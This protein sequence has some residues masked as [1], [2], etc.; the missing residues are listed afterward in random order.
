M[1]ICSF[2]ED[3]FSDVKRFTIPKIVRWLA[4]NQASNVIFMKGKNTWNITTIWFLLSSNKGDTW[5]KIVL[6]ELCTKLFTTRLIYWI[7][8]QRSG[9]L[10]YKKRHLHKWCNNYKDT[11]VTF[12]SLNFSKIQL[13]LRLNI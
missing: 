1:K 13:F 3:L 6:W 2:Q 10:T 7:M 4:S 5:K 11:L 8:A 9:Y 12:Y